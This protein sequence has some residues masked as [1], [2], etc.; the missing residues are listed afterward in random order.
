MSVSSPNVAS[1]KLKS[2]VGMN[3]CEFCFLQIDPNCSF[4]S[5][6]V[7]LAFPR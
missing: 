4:F 1:K 3:Q 6:V 2:S 5:V 7:D